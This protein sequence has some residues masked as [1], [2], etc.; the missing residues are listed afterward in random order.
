MALS[1]PIL[2]VDDD[3]FVRGVITAALAAAGVS[4]VRACASGEEAL[5][6]VATVRPGLILMDFMLPG[7]DGAATWEAIRKN[8]SPPLPAVVFLTARA[9][10][11]AKAPGVLGAIRKP[12]NPATLVAELERLCG[13]AQSAPDSTDRLAGVRSEFLRA[14]PAAAAV[15]NAGRA[16][17]SAGWQTDAAKALLAKAH[18]LAGSAGLFGRHGLGAAAGEAEGLLLKYLKREYP[19]DSREISALQHAIAALALACTA[20]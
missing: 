10:S 5:A 8:L 13:A 3:F 7:L 20:D 12:F 11:L 15:I 6:I 17:L 9:E 1:S 18:T 14:L 2:I 4:A 19:P 16:E